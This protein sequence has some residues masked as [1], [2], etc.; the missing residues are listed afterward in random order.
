MLNM[1][2]SLFV[3]RKFWLK[4]TIVNEAVIPYHT[5]YAYYTIFVIC[6]IYNYAFV[7]IYANK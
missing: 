2:T 1:N 3:T 5:D 4:L 7:G 6:R